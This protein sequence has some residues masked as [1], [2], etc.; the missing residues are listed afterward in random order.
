MKVVGLVTSYVKNNNIAINGLSCYRMVQHASMQ[1]SVDTIV[2][3][4]VDL[5]YVGCKLC[6]V[7]GSRVLYSS[8]IIVWSLPVDLVMGL[9]SCDNFLLIDWLVH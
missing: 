3:F 6:C 1:A 7:R 8:A 2:Y 4:Q 5:F 9:L